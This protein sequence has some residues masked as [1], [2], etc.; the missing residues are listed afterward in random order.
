MGDLLRPILAPLIF[1]V[2]R[3][4]SA[5]YKGLFAWWLDEY[6]GRK[7]DASFVHEIREKVPFLFSEH[8]ARVVRTQGPL[9]RSM[10]AAYAT[11][12]AGNLRLF[13]LRGRGD[14]TVRIAPHH[15]P[16]DWHDLALVAMV[17]ETPHGMKSRETLYWLDDVARLLRSKWKI[18]NDALSAESYAIIRRRLDGIYDLP[19]DDLWRAGISIP[20]HLRTG[21]RAPLPRGR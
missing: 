9:R 7:A 20:K 13:F 12:E 14:L 1:I 6:D 11:I 5:V 17:A 18:L 15:E 10:G 21:S 4:A 2:G 3:I 16:S 19:A 8:A